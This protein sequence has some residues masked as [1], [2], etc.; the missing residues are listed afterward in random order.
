MASVRGILNFQSL[1]ELTY[2]KRKLVRAVQRTVQR[3]LREKK[4]RTSGT[5]YRTAR[6][7]RFLAELLGCERYINVD[8]HVYIACARVPNSQAFP[9]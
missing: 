8:S 5:T 2:E 9:K 4:T 6:A 3:V 7:K 1:N